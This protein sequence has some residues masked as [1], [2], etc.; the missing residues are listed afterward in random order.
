MDG[1]WG[2]ESTEAPSSLKC[3]A[4]EGLL[5][6]AKPKPDVVK[7]ILHNI[8]KNPTVAEEIDGYTFVDGYAYKIET[9]D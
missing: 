1:F 9:E 8:K 4:E 3:K 6:S 7:A 5:F 2:F